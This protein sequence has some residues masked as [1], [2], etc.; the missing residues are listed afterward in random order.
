MPNF[1]DEMAFSVSY[2]SFNYE[3]YAYYNRQFR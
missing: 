1:N 3:N 2:Y